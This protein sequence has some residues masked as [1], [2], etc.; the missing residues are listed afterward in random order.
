MLFSLLTDQVDHADPHPSAG[1]MVPV[2]TRAAHPDDRFIRLR[3]KPVTSLQDAFSTGEGCILR[4][5]L[6]CCMSSWSTRPRCADRRPAHARQRLHGRYSVV[7]I[8]ATWLNAQPVSP[9]SSVLAVWRARQTSWWSCR[10][11]RLSSCPVSL[12]SHGV[13]RRDCRTTSTR[14]RYPHSTRAIIRQVGGRR[15]PATPL[16]P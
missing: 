12:S 7:C 2:R 10:L 5:A 13:K 11:C 14:T 6:L 8:A 4:N 3:T 9:S 15:C 16:L 1:L